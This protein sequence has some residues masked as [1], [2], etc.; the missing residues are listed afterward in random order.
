MPQ[1]DFSP[2]YIY[3]NPMFMITVSTVVIEEN[4][5]ILVNGGIDTSDKVA[6]DIYRFPGGIVRAGQESIQFA[7]VRHIKEQLG[8]VVKK[9]ALIPIDFRSEPERS[10]DGNIV[11]IGFVTTVD[12]KID[13][14]CNSQ[15]PT[16]K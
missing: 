3:D 5:V 14:N 7:A 15:Q 10:S 13:A 1:I 2:K 16:M 4:G 8:I 6:V 9:D 11:D 12:K